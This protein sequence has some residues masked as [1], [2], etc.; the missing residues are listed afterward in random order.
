MSNQMNRSKV[1]Y[2]NL[3]ARAKENYNY[4][5]LAALLADYGY[6]CVRLTDDYNGADLLALR[7]GE[8]ALHIQLKSRLTIDRKYMGKGLYMSFPVAGKWYVLEH[9]KLTQIQAESG[10]LD[11]ESWSSSGSYSTA[12]PSVAMLHLLREYAL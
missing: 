5:K 10:K 11:T 4:A 8:D 3:N 6:S 7:E 12:K 2:S 1:D 9:D